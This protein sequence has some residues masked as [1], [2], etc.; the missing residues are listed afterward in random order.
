MSY[1]EF[2]VGGP[3]S[4]GQTV[5]VILKSMRGRKEFEI[6]TVHDVLTF[7]WGDERLVLFN[8]YGAI[9]V[10]DNDVVVGWETEASE[11]G[12]ELLTSPIDGLEPVEEDDIRPIPEID[13]V[14]ESVTR[15]EDI[16]DEY[17]DR[18]IGGGHYPF[19]NLGK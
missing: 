3:E 16:E 10:Y 19:R 13:N 5:R 9:A 7:S 4:D 12:D 8:Q 11:E 18:G 14:Y 15:I 6:R 17:E 1:R 2:K